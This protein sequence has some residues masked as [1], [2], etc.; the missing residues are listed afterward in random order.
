MAGSDLGQIKSHPNVVV[1]AIAEID[2]RRQAEQ[3]FKALM[4]WDW[5]EMLEKEARTWIMNVSTLIICMPA[6]A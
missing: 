1:R 4:L 6:W 3:R 2:R 5:R